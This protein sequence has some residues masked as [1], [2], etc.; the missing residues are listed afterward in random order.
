MNKHL[1]KISVTIILLL[2]S[3]ATFAKNHCGNINIEG[4][5]ADSSLESLYESWEN[6][7]SY[8]NKY[9]KFGCYST[10]YFGESIADSIVKRLSDHWD[11]LNDLASLTRKNKKFENFLLSKI[12]ATVSDRDL[13]KIHDLANN[14]CPK[15]LS[16]LCMSID[17]QVLKAYDEMGNV[18]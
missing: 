18:N 12:N 16:G 4:E 15:E 8:Y 5:K 3:G 11:S 2:I 9:S 13:L 10:G 6:I 1:Y 7:Y 14:N 17:K